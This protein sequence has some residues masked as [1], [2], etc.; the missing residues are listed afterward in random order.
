MC[1]ISSLI[2]HA[3]AICGLTD[4]VAEEGNLQDTGILG[5]TAAQ[6]YLSQF[7]TLSEENLVWE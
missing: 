1:I 6:E 7:D 2:I 3:Y 5:L 4:E